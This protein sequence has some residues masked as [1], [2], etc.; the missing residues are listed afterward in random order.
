M[1]YLLSFF[2]GCFLLAGLA[3]AQERPNPVSIIELIAAPE[4][5]EGKLVTVRGF[6]SINHEKPNG[7]YNAVL[8]LHQE[9][10]KNVLLSN[11]IGLVP[12]EQML[13]EEEKINR[14]YVMLTGVFRGVHA[15]GDDTVHVGVIK[16]IRSCTVW[17]D[18]N[19]PIT[20]KPKAQKPTK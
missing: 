18:P 10:A 17:S 7:L 2:V 13:R 20:E 1:K 4:K 15:A 19:R 8:Y 9:D 16:D 3:L 11:Q 5:F 14:M 6:L 12:N